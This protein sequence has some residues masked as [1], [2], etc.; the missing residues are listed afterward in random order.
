MSTPLELRCPACDRGTVVPEGIE[1]DD[2][3]N[4]ECDNCQSVLRLG[5]Q[6]IIADPKV[7]WEMVPFLWLARNEDY[8]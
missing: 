6:D 3:I 1:M 5:G 8:A 4:F 2:A 7:G